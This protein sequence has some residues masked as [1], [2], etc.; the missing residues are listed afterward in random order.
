MYLRSLHFWDV[1]GGR[2][3]VNDFS[4]QPVIPILT[5]FS[6]A[7]QWLLF[8]RQIQST[9]PYL[10][11][12]VISVSKYFFLSIKLV[13]KQARH[14]LLILC[15]RSYEIIYIVGMGSVLSI[16]FSLGYIEDSSSLQSYWCEN[17]KS[18]KSV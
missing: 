6:R 13:P 18:H 3:L 14:L 15:L 7:C 9:S 11:L 12:L 17:L 1:S 2:Y 4:G 5:M 10:I 16:M 8:G